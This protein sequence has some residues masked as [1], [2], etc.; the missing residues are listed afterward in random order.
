MRS[1]R[2][3]TIYVAVLLCFAVFVMFYWKGSSGRHSRL[4]KTDKYKTYKTKNPD[5]DSHIALPKNTF[6]KSQAYNEQEYTTVN[7][8]SV[9]VKSKST[10]NHVEQKDTVKED[11]EVPQSKNTYNPELASQERKNTVKKMCKKHNIT[12]DDIM[13]TNTFGISSKHKFMINLIGK[14]GSTTLKHII[15]SLTPPN[16]SYIHQIPWQHMSKYKNYTKVVFYRDPLERLVSYYYYAVDYNSRAKNLYM[17]YL[18]YLEKLTDRDVSGEERPN[19]TFSELVQIITTYGKIPRGFGANQYACSHI[20]AYDV[21]FIGH[22]DKMK[23]DIP[24]MFDL[25]GISDLIKLPEQHSQTGHV[26][27]KDTVKTLPKYLF[28]RII[29]YYKLDYEILGFDVPKF[30]SFQLKS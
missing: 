29:E 3:E 28:N 12:Y 1:G 19:I 25:A 22:L 27:Y 6:K 9:Q 8:D 15:S 21:D 5:L 14:V 30:S 13:G 7:E 17:F 16:T 11:Q 20:C 2:R 18:P 23:Y 10:Y 24:Y 26:K 4:F